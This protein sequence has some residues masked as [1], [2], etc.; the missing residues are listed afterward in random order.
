MY[1]LSAIIFF[2]LAGIG[3]LA[4]SMRKSEQSKWLKTLASMLK[5]S[6]DVVFSV[7]YMSVL[8][9][10]LFIFSCDFKAT[11]VV[12][13]FFTTEDGAP[14]QC[15]TMPN[16]IVLGVAGFTSLIFV[17]ASASIQTASCELNPCAKGTLASPAAAMKIKV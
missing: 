12:H 3:L 10:F 1:A 13:F 17:V 4:W 8:D 9:Y 11:P 2:V 15:L 6:S 14:L 7:M 5:V 16:I